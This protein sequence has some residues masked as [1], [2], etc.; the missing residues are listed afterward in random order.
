[1]AQIS[2]S[3]KEK[4]RHFSVLAKQRFPIERILLYGSH[5]KGV[6]TADS[7]I[8]IAVVVNVKDHLKRIEITAG[9]IH[10]ANLVD[11]A[12]EPRCVFEDEYNN[13][14]QASILSEIIQSGIEIS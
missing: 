12:I 5:A 10:C 2:N 3:I 9:L 13:H 6:N 4:I 8:D 7:D 11:S 14:D 1:M